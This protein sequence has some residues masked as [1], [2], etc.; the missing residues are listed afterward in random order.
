MRN[1]PED[2]FPKSRHWLNAWL[3]VSTAFVVF[4][5]GKIAMA[6]FFFL[7][8]YSSANLPTALIHF[9]HLWDHVLVFGVSM[10]SAILA[11]RWIE[12]KFLAKSRQSVLGTSLVFTLLACCPFDLVFKSEPVMASP[13]N[14]AIRYNYSPQTIEMLID[15]YPKLL[16]GREGFTPLA[17]VAYQNKTNL[18]QLFIQ[19]GADV[20]IA[21]KE[22]TQINAESA[23]Q[24][25][26]QYST[27]RN[28]TV[29]TNGIL[30]NP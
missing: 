28:D 26:L 22:L 21:V 1:E 11:S 8:Q 12:K 7:I 16:K 30:P 2:K 6:A 27:N 17:S 20:D 10:T 14:I 4:R 19:K 15:R 13:L 9:V 3:A 23:I 25:V 5:I 18:V 29:R 24:L